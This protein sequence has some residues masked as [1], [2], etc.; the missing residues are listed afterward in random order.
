MALCTLFVL[1][2]LGIGLIIVWLPLGIVALW[3]I[4][5]IWRGWMSLREGKPMYV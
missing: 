1:F 2:T 3:F 4:Y 5:R